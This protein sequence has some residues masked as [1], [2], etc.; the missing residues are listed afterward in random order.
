MKHIPPMGVTGPTIGPIHS[1]P[2]PFS[3]TSKYRLPEK[4]T[5]PSNIDQPAQ[6]NHLLPEFPAELCPEL[7]PK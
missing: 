5:I 3:R 1:G 2:V 7:L 4:Q 6:R